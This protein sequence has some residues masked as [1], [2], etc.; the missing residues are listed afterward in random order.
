MKDHTRRD[1][2]KKAGLSSVAAFTL[3]QIVSSPKHNENPQRSD[4]KKP[5]SQKFTFLFQGDS[6]TDGNRTRD[7]DWNHIMGHG[8]AYLIAS[9]LWYD[10]AD[11]DLMFINRGVSG[12]TV[13]DLAARWQTDALDLKPDVLSILI[14]I[15]DVYAI[16]KNL[17]KSTPDDFRSA[18]AQLLERSRNALPDTLIVLCE[19]FILPLGRTLEEPEIWKAELEPRRNIVRD[20]AG[21]FDALFINLQQPFIDACRKAPA[22]YW[23]WDGIHPM[24]AGHELIARQWLSIVKNEMQFLKIEGVKI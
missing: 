15:N 11:K 7:N 17:K 22:K 4:I 6:I 10:N 2:L 16:V 14:G 20:L 9:R 19:P 1:F 5:A 3:P 21:Q 24:P 8:Y 12:N 18:Y 23:I 13:F